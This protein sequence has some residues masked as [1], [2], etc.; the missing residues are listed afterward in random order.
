M[1]ARV[2]TSAL[3]RL[4]AAHAAGHGAGPNA[5]SAWKFL[6]KFFLLAPRML[7]ARPEQQGSQQLLAA[8]RPGPRQPPTELDP[9]VASE[10]KRQ[11]ACAKVRQGELSRARH[12]LTAAELAPGTEATWDALTDPAKRP[13]EARVA[14]P[15]ELPQYRPELP[16][17]LSTQAV[18]SALREAR[19]GGA[20]GLS[21]SCHTVRLPG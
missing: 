17:Q 2:D 3:T 9:A 12:V 20:A 15:A 19:R 4:R 13:P 8:A 11:R 16:V 10:R 14:P 1:R 5:S 6:K 7:L 18:A 21:L